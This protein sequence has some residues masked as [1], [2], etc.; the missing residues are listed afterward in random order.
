MCSNTNT[1]YPAEPAESMDNREGIDIFLMKGK[2]S[3]SN[4]HRYGAL[5]YFTPSA[6][7]LMIKDG[8]MS[9]VN[10]TRIDDIWFI[11]SHTDAAVSYSNG[12]QKVFHIDSV[13]S[14]KKDGE[15]TLKMKISVGEFTAT[16]TYANNVKN[17]SELHDDDNVELYIL[18]RRIGVRA[19]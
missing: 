4:S 12:D 1:N 11:M 8:K 17:L 13:K 16:G 19:I 9:S 2:I 14:V 3:V 7:I 10:A 6:R 5:L 15:N 18:R